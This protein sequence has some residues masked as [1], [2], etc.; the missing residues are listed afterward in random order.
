MFVYVGRV[1]FDANP[2]ESVCRNYLMYRVGIFLLHPCEPF[3]TALYFVY[4]RYGLFPILE[5]SVAAYAVIVEF[6]YALSHK[7]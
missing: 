5:L 6:W 4:E 1:L 7:E 3:P 2:F